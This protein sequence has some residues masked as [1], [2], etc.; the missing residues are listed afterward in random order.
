VDQITALT[1]VS[2]SGLG[3]RACPI[4]AIELLNPDWV[5]FSVGAT[6]TYGHV[7]NQTKTLFSSYG[8]PWF[9]TDQNGTIAQTS[10]NA[11]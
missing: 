6:K 4:R 9:R 5:T 11:L 7:H 2:T 10:C 3:C 8:K 1:S